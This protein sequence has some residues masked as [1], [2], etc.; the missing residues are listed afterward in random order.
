M[1]TCDQQ[2]WNTFARETITTIKNA[3]FI[4]LC[5]VEDTQNHQN[6]RDKIGTLT[7]KRGMRLEPV[8]CN[9]LQLRRKEIRHIHSSYTKES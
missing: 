9:T 4:S 8:K 2:S 5:I 6:D 7:R 3:K 1:G